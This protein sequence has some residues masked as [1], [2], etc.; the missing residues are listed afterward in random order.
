MFIWGLEGLG[1][2]VVLVLVFSFVQVLFLFVL[3]L[4]LL[5]CWCCSCAFFCFFVFCFF[6]GFEGQVR[7]PKGPPHLALNPPY[8]LFVFF[9]VVCFFAFLSL[10]V[11]EKKLFLPLKKAIL[12][13]CF[14]CLPLFLFSLFWASPVF[15]F[16]FFVS[17]S[18]SLS[19]PLSCYFLSSFLSV[20]HFRIWFLLFLLFCLRFGFKM[21]FCFCFL[22]VVF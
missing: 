3:V 20:S 2:F 7:W 1:V 21:F 6:G 19:L 11:I 13:V 14:L 5:C 12:C 4:F 18:L 16:S 10:L 17:L 8:F 9:F 15:T 22:L